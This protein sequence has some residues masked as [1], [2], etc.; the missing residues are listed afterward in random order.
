MRIEE[1]LSVRYY[2]SVA[3]FSE[4]FGAA[5]NVILGSPPIADSPADEPQPNGEVSS[6]ELTADYKAKKM[7][8]NRIIKAV[9]GLLEEAMR[10]ESELRRKPFEK[11]L[12][13]LDRLFDSSVR[14]RRDSTTNSQL[15]NGDTD[16]ALGRPNM[17]G[18]TLQYSDYKDQSAMEME[19][20][21]AVI[22]ASRRRLSV[23]SPV[24]TTTRAESARQSGHRQ[25]PTP[26]SMPPT[27][28]VSSDDSKS[29]GTQTSIELPP[30]PVTPPLS[31]RGDIQ[32]LSHGGI[33]WYMETF[34]PVGT[35]IE[36]ERWTGREL[37][38]GMSEDLSDMDEEELSGLVEADE[39]GVRLY[40]SLANGSLLPAAKAVDAKK[41]KAAAKKKRRR[42]FY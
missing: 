41:R 39:V 4:D 24:N 40:S 14:S 23:G 10:K 21:P 25:Q 7:L 33:P 2:T 8:A 11:E 29:N 20:D 31:S 12:R 5:V 15:G 38:R 16:V 30:E 34:D 3:V 19:I 6:K 9:K 37:V 42:G 32:P 27:N 35:T 17:N 18:D 1:N 13:D 36:E 26:D 28:G 22:R